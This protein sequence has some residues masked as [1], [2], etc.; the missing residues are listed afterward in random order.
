M[1]LFSGRNAAEA[2]LR[3]RVTRRVALTLLTWILSATC[4]QAV[5]VRGRLTDA[6]G[7]AVAGGQVR[8]VAGG[9]T[10][11]MAYAGA[12]GTFE[13]RS[14]ESGRFSLLGSAGGY[15]P[16]FGM[17]FYGGATDVL[18]QDVVLAT[19]TVRQDVTVSATGI[20]TPLPQLTSPVTV[21]PD[22]A[23]TL[24]LGVVDELRQTPG[25]FVVQSGQT[26]GVTSL[27]LRGGNSTANLVTIDG[28]PADE[29]GGIY[30]FGTV[31]STAISKIEVVRGPDS[32]MYGTDAGAGVVTIETP[33]GTTAT[34][35]IDYS[36]DA[37]NLYTWRDEVAVGGA[38]KRF[39]Y[40]GAF[41][42]LD[43]SN[44]LPMDTYHSATSAMNVGYDINGNTQVRATIRNAVSATGVPGPFDFQGISNSSKQSDQDLYAGLTV[45][46]R[47]KGSW[48]NL[49]RYGIARVREQQQQFGN[50]GTPVIFEAGTPYE[51]TE[52]FGNVVT[53]RG[54]NGYTAT[55]QTSI[56][57]GNTDQD[58]NRDQIY[59]QSDYSV[60]PHF[61]ALLGF[62]YDKERGSFNYPEFGEFEKT[63][64]TNFEYNLQFQGEF[65][66]KLFYS[67]GGA[68]EKNHLYGIAGTPRVGLS[69]V[70]VRPSAKALHGTRL[71]ANVAT[72]VQEPTLALEANSLYEQLLA[73]GDI[74]TI[75]LYHI[76]PQSAERSRTVDVGV[77]QNIFGERLV[78]K[79]GY[80]HNVFDHQL[81]GV[82]SQTLDADFGYNIPPNDFI[83]TA[84]LNSLAY[85]AQGAE[86]EVAW[87][88]RPQLLLRGGYT[89]LDAR[90][91]QS[92]ASDAVAANQG[93]P[94]E[95]PNLPGIAIGSLSPLVG[96]RPFRRAPNTGYVDALYTQPRFTLDFKAAMAS[97]SDD[98]TY[99]EYS[100]LEGGNTLL[101]PNR[102]LDF[103]Y[104][105]LDIGGTYKWKHGLTYFAQINNVLNDQH[106]G[107]IGFP[108]LPLT[109][110]TGL[111]LHLG[112]N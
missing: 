14:S 59:Y 55:G 60:S 51:Y 12:D 111:K 112:Q 49:V 28:I 110:R 39:D 50:V 76:T 82:D 80:F 70:P 32:A 37:G 45:E 6:L 78:L 19:N 92:F 13:L 104:V 26:G 29:V 77:D 44:A 38:Y 67:A 73:D 87:Q 48:H 109:F 103:G 22:S 54:A 94:T 62:R 58:S 47:Y 83:Y 3:A 99:L 40:F 81:E 97:R 84:Y 65:W 52:Y 101:L 36:G 16:G 56:Y 30:D 66:N 61:I 98:S 106:I 23:L 90:V 2:S 11:A 74:T 46:N 100:D 1:F 27:F 5:V 72:G 21:I 102:N 8:L 88:P 63:K 43:T 79:A 91:L 42:R 107:P 7:K 25:A 18:E 85:R 86:V 34:P 71:R 68:I 20:P 35:V 96:A 69:Y 33:R 89:Y 95:N 15:L 31:S 41:S 93:V 9:K 53:I 4:A 57:G 10:V 108:G 64:R 75:A 105:K 24:Q 17:D